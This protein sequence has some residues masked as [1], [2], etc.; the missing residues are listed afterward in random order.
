MDIV[1]YRALASRA[2]VPLWMLEELGLQYR[3]VMVDLRSPGGP[4][5][6]LR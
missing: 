5:S 6:C 4:R 1:I 3:S 2:I